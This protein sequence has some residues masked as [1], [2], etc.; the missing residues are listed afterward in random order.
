[1]HDDHEGHAAIR[2]RRAEERLERGQPAR[3]AAQAHD[4]HFG[5]AFGGH[6][7]IHILALFLL[8]RVGRERGQA[9]IFR[10]V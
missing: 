10:G 7:I 2:R 6:D 3:R 4:R 1:M 5:I 8:D 9:V